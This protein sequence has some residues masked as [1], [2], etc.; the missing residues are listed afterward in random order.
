MHKQLF[1]LGGDKH[2]QRE[3]NV[4]GIETKCQVR[5][6]CCECLV[7]ARLLHNTDPQFLDEIIV[8]VARAMQNGQIA[9]VQI[10]VACKVVVEL[11][12]TSN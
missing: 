1:F 5:H 3:N 11:H 9:L 2:T 7:V 10:S 4:R 12:N 6:L 8:S